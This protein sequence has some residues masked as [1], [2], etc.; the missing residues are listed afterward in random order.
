MVVL[1]CESFWAHVLD[2]PLLCVTSAWVSK[3]KFALD[4][5]LVLAKE[6]FLPIFVLSAEICM[7]WLPLTSH[8]L[9]PTVWVELELVS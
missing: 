1:G 3:L 9:I 5:I 2:L 6:S 7:G 4:R 8:V